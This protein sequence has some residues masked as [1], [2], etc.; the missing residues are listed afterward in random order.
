MPGQKS[1]E[2]NSLLKVEGFEVF[3]GCVFLKSTDCLG[4]CIHGSIVLAFGLTSGK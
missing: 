1:L 2:P 3:P 4:R